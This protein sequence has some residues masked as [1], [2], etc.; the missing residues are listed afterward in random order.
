VSDVSTRVGGLGAP[1]PSPPDSRTYLAIDGAQV[2]F[3]GGVPP[4][5]HTSN[6]SF[7]LPGGR[8][9]HPFRA[10]RAGYADALQQWIAGPEFGVQILETFERPVQG[11][12]LRLAA[13]RQRSSRAAWRSLVFAV[14][15][16]AHGSVVTARHGSDIAG[17]ARRL[18]SLPYRAQPG[19]CTLALR[20]DAA[21]RPPTVMMHVDGLG[22]LFVRPH[23]SQLL[24]RVPT[25]PGLRTDGGELFRMRADRRTLLLVTGSA[26]VDIEP[27]VDTA[28]ALEAAAALHIEWKAASA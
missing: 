25:T 15:E 7:V 16:H 19:G 1:A 28:V 17:V 20:V 24:A 23:T 5:L 21:L 10:H 26:V 3:A 11:G 14:W 22:V 4:A 6:A 9:S 27:S 2:A 18:V 8:R 12:R 13:V